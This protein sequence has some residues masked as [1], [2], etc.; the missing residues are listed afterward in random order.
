M[1]SRWDFT[2]P[3]VLSTHYLRKQSPQ[4]AVCSDPADAFLLRPETHSLCQ[5]P[6]WADGWTMA[7]LALAGFQ[8]WMMDHDKYLLKLVLIIV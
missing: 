4:C 3:P 8:A 1:S 5:G 7:G 6:W 2:L